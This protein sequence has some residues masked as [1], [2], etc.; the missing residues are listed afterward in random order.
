MSFD[1]YVFPPP[2]PMTIADVH[3]LIEACEEPVGRADGASQPSPEMAGFLTELER[4]W[5]TLEED[6]AATPW[7]SSLPEPEPG[8][9]IELNIQWPR[10]QSMR[11]AIVEIAAVANVIVYDPQASELIRPPQGS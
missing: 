9:G 10:A 1:L 11:S 7:S 8:G 2:G 6:L 5:P 4:R 3:R